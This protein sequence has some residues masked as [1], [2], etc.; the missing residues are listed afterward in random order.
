MET[1]HQK[2]AEEK[3]FYR[4]LD[5]HN[6]HASCSCQ[7][8]AVIF[9]FMIA[10]SVFISY[11]AITSLQSLKLNPIKNGHFLSGNKNSK[12]ADTITIYQSDLQSKISGIYGKIIPLKNKQVL[13]KHEGLILNG[14]TGSPSQK[15]SFIADPVVRDQKIALENV[16][17]QNNSSKY[18]SQF[19]SPIYT[20][21]AK[22][23]AA[24]INSM[25]SFNISDI[26]LKDGEMIL[27]I[28]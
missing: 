22:A 12:Q 13:I 19:L 10:A 14:E 6:T 2:L 25:V 3:E 9:I 18:T 5:Q 11:Y 28:Y 4:D 15:L 1:G 26:Q 17:V 27:S 7:L 23:M 20:Q 8:L 16:R 24:S 21:I